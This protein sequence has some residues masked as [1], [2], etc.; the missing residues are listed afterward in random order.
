[1]LA[2]DRKKDESIF[3]G[4]DIEILV[5]DIRG[6]KVRLGINAPNNIKI[7]RKEVYQAIKREKL[8]AVGL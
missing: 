2:L 8:S 5:I 4:D 7:H 6:P 3:V 1:M